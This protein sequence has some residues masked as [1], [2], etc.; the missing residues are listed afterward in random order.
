MLRFD[1]QI[2]LPAES[3]ASAQGGN[4]FS[5]SPDMDGSACWMALANRPGCYIWYPILQTDAP[6]TW[7][8]GYSGGFAQG[9]DAHGVFFR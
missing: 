2:R 6:V 5:L 9:R 1:K 3:G 8:G 4:S 7:I